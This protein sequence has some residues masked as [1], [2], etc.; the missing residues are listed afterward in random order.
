MHHWVWHTWISSWLFTKGFLEAENVFENMWNFS[1]NNFHSTWQRKSSFLCMDDCMLLNRFLVAL[2]FYTVEFYL[3]RSAFSPSGIL[4]SN[5]TWHY[6]IMV[7]TIWFFSFI[8]RPEHQ[9]IELLLLSYFFSFDDLL[10]VFVCLYQARKENI[11]TLIFKY[12][13]QLY[14]FNPGPQ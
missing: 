12:M 9:I 6:K 7:K 2:L 13:P 5:W 14:Q 8:T 1:H 3:A 11:I 10:F 4:F